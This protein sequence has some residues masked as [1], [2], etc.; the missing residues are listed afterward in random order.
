MLPAVWM[1]FG[2]MVALTVIPVA[3]T[4]SDVLECR[5]DN[6]DAGNGQ[7]S[8]HSNLRPRGIPKGIHTGSHGL[9]DHD[10]RWTVSALTLRTVSEANGRTQYVFGTRPPCSVDVTLYR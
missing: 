4:I 7:G 8:A 5:K 1:F 2:I 9:G 3:I 10:E 6:K